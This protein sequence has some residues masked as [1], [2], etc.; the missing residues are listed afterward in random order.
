MMAT[1]DVD[2]NP[3]SLSGALS[4]RT[5]LQGV[6][7]AALAG[8]SVLRLAG[9]TYAF[10]AESDGEVIR[11]LDQ[12]EP[13]PL[14]EAI[15]QQLEWEKL[16]SWLTPPDQF[17]VIKHFNLPELDESDWSLQISGLVAKPMALTLADLKARERREVTFTME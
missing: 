7:A 1:N 14:P 9:P 13:N 10:Q 8:V 4:R 11:W 3:S 2:P 15:L 17:F 16:D 5:V 12:P 6:G